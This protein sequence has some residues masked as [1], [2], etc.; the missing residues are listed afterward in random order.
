VEPMVRVTSIGA[1][2]MMM[3]L[4]LAGCGGDDETT[5]TVAATEMTAA[6]GSGADGAEV[7][8]AICAEC[9]GA[10]GTGGS[11]PDLTMRTDLTRE[12]IVDLVINGGTIMPS[13][14]AELSTEEIE[15]VADYVLS[16]IV[17][18]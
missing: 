15:A 4:A 18:Q 16:D 1:L 11:G 9:H 10:D 5:T 6:G 8:A 14:G 17:Q 3:L 7:F 12:W 13:P 2:V